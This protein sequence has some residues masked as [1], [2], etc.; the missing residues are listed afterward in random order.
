MLGTAHNRATMKSARCQRAGAT[1]FRCV[2][3]YDTGGNATEEVWLWVRLRRTGGLCVSPSG[4]RFVPAA[5][6]AKGR[7][8]KGNISDAYNAFRREIGVPPARKGDCIGHG[9]QSRFAG[10]KSA[11]SC[12]LRRLSGA[13]GCRRVLAAAFPR[14]PSPQEFELRVVRTVGPVATCAMPLSGYPSGM[15]CF[16]GSDGKRHRVSASDEGTSL[17]C[18]GMVGCRVR[19]RMRR[20]HSDAR[21]AR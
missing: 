6:L 11:Y 4:L 3:T 15:A 5:C 14:K 19:T 8:A 1:G 18:S 7:R 2:T 21:A 17:P 10:P 13:P 20:V 9:W 16:V 12:A